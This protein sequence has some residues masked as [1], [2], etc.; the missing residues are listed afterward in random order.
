MK[1]TVRI[2]AAVD[3]DLKSI[4]FE[5]M[6]R[7]SKRARER[8]RTE[9]GG[10]ST[11]VKA[12]AR[13]DRQ[14]ETQARIQQEKKLKEIGVAEHKDKLARERAAE[15]Q[16][17]AHDLAMHR[18]TVRAKRREEERSSAEGRRRE[19]A[20]DAKEEREEI[21]RKKRLAKLHTEREGG[22]R[23]FASTAARTTAGIV[24][25]GVGFAADV[26]RGAGLSFDVAGAVKKRSLLE[27]TAID[28]SNSAY[29]EQGVG[30]STKRVDPRELMA[31]AQEIGAATA[32]DPTEALK[33]LQAFTGITGDLATA[34]AAMVDM[35]RLSKATG[36]NFS[37]VVA[38]AGEI[39]KAMGDAAKSEGEAATKAKAIYDVMR[40]V[41]GQG[42]LG[43]VEM[44]DNAKFFARQASAATQF[45]G[46][47]ATNILKMGALSQEARGGG[48][49]WNA[50]TS[51]AAVTGLVNIFR[52]PARQKHF[53]AEKIDVIDK[54]TK[55]IRDPYKIMLEAIEKTNADPKKLQPMFA[56]VVGA[57][58]MQQFANLYLAASGGRTDAK[59]KAAGRAAVEAEFERM[60]KKATMTEKE[61][62]DSLGNA[63]ATTASKVE[64][65]QQ[66]LDR[67]VGDM[68][69]R[70]IPAMLQLSDPALKAA[71]AMTKMAVWAAENPLGAGGAAIGAGVAKAVADVLAAKVAGGLV[72]ALAGNGALTGV[73]ISSMI[74]AS[75]GMMAI[76]QVVKG[77][78]DAQKRRLTDEAKALN[79]RS[80]LRA[81]EEQYNEEVQAGAPT[82]E[83]AA[84]LDKAK[85]EA[86]KQAEVLT[87]RIA[88]GEAF[89]AD[90]WGEKDDYGSA[91]M[92]SMFGTD[93]FGTGMN[94]NQYEDADQNA[95]KLDE[96]KA[97]LAALKE[98][99]GG[100]KR[101]MDG[102]LKVSVEN[103]PGVA[104]ALPTAV[105]GSGT[106]G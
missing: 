66:K 7:A 94:L 28:L 3:G 98:V 103:L 15:Q 52:T 22:V 84:R 76:D 50:A 9:M 39:S 60:T 90:E 100:V 43:S 38:T 37:E 18:D 32:T 87:Q 13:A 31:Q 88:S 36:S 67:V 49:A 83:T 1:I 48:G 17:R 56:N 10:A 75:V 5:P 77:G 41:A 106:G 19:R 6:E 24:H 69:D 57:R 63:M 8:I 72:G 70:V 4:L 73:V 20:E 12:Q 89:K 71:N 80:A 30:I 40:G 54:K 2:A 78:E 51:A 16:Q 58:S 64:L 74:I 46:D 65:F 93:Y 42:K 85:E 35:A 79:A 99:M 91:A 21:A 45:E 25:R 47:A 96:L 23:E 97:E 81:A 55:K 26:A 53:E 68:A 104:P 82:P 27:S 95:A 29:Q 11:D 105:S 14:V 92:N 59:S 62:T 102:T 86:R 44:R 33:G 61:V 101:T 34:R